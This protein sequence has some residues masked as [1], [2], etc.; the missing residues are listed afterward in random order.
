MR[1]RLKHRLLGAA[2]LLAL[3]VLL[4]PGFFRDKDLYQI[5]TQSQVPDK[6]S[7]TAVD[8]DGPTPVLDIEPAPEP[9]TMFVPDAAPADSVVS[10]V[11]SSSS[12]SSSLVTGSGVESWVI[13]V[14]SFG[15]KEAAEKLV[16]ELQAEG[17]KA[18]SRVVVRC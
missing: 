16:N 4:L 18:Y 2:I 5:N 7:I 14:A 13:Q 1:E 12:V 9:E 17:Y 11:V 10:S 15:Q 8:S 3:G 6:P